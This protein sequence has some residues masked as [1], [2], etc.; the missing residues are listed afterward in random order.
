VSDLA[1]FVAVAAVPLGLCLATWTFFRSRAARQAH[2]GAPALLAGNGLVLATLFAFVLLGFEAHLRFF[3]DASDGDNRT[4]VSQRWFARHWRNNNVRLRDDVDYALRRTPGKRRI[5][6]VG[7]SFTAGHGVPDVSVRYANLLRAANPDWEVHA[8]AIPGLET[9]EEMQLL[10]RLLQRGYELDVVVLAFY[11]ENVGRFV[12]ELRKYFA[13]AARP[14]PPPLPFLMRHSY[15]I[16]TFAYRAQSRWMYARGYWSDVYQRAYA[17]EPWEGQQRA[18][19]AFRALVEAHGGR[20]ATITFPT[21]AG[22]EGRREMIE[23]IDAFW[24]AEGVPHLELLSVLEPHSVED[25]VANPHDA[26]PSALTHRLAAEALQRFLDERV[27]GA[28]AR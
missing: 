12:P 25:L 23:R 26:H 14:L 16:D 1:G 17:G 11:I 6:F 9:P 8:L 7:D 20:F 21:L 2:P 18:F 28:P 5:S 24:A 10:Q 4:R 13:E 19:R 22:V 27:L 15:A 3:Y